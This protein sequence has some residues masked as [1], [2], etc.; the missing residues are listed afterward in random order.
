MTC[1]VLTVLP[2]WSVAPGHVCCSVIL[3]VWESWRPSD[4]TLKHNAA[5]MR[6]EDAIASLMCLANP[7]A[8]P[9]GQN[10]LNQE[11][12]VLGSK[13]PYS[14][15]LRCWGFWPLYRAGG[16]A[17]HVWFLPRPLSG[18]VSSYQHLDPR[19]KKRTPTEGPEDHKVATDRAAKKRTLRGLRPKPSTLQTLYILAFGIGNLSFFVGKKH[20]HKEGRLEPICWKLAFCTFLLQFCRSNSSIGF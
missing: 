9:K 1:L 19:P 7:P 10:P 15:Y 5:K 11:K 16:F 6:H 4:G 13:S 12:R 3:L 8:L 17:N 18:V 20:W 2:Q 14:D